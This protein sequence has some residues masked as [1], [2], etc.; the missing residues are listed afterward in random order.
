MLRHVNMVEVAGTSVEAHDPPQVAQ[1]TALLAKKT[2]P[3]FEAEPDARKIIFSEVVAVTYRAK[4]GTPVH[5][6]LF[7]VTAD[8]V[9]SLALKDLEGQ[10]DTQKDPAHVA[11]GLVMMRG[12]LVFR[13]NGIDQ[14]MEMS[15]VDLQ[16]D[17]LGEPIAGSTPG[18]EAVKN[19]YV[20]AVL[21]LANVPDLVAVNEYGVPEGCT[22]FLDEIFGSV[23]FLQFRET[24][25]IRYFAEFDG[26][27]W[28]PMGT[29]PSALGRTPQDIAEYH[30]GLPHKDFLN[31]MHAVW[32][33]DGD[34][35]KAAKLLGVVED[36]IWQMNAGQADSAFCSRPADWTPEDSRRHLL[37]NGY[38]LGD[39]VSISSHLPAPEM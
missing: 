17:K 32:L 1:F 4:D 7:G 37:A 34:A 26:N 20:A 18:R 15:I 11:F 2:A 10:V 21:P 14:K 3:V 23:R 39:Q 36:R 9:V 5:G 8:D 19:A 33:A 38:A 22:H 12:P 35:P 25:S 24:S 6:G 30:A 13:Q 28:E 31:V 16:A 29:Q 27:R